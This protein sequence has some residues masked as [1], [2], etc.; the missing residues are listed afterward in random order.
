M[1]DPQGSTGPAQ[2]PDA[3]K[4][5]EVKL[6]GTAILCG[7]PARYKYVSDTRKAP[8]NQEIFEDPDRDESFTIELFELKEH[9]T[10]AG[11]AS[12]FLQD[13]AAKQGTENSLAVEEESRV[14]AVAIPNLDPSTLANAVTSTMA[15]AKGSQGSDAAKLMRVQLANIRLH[16]VE[17]DIVIAVYKPHVIDSEQ[18]ESVATV[19][20]GPELPANDVPA[21]DV[22]KQVLSTF[23]IL[24]WSL[25]GYMDDDE[26]VV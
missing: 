16:R 25:F 2:V 5:V 9:V 4:S 17:T 6:F 26:L 11:S 20:A 18:S 1:D 3:E 15:I 24:D 21:N 13:L 22:F 7:L 8:A 23:K 10:N 14:P 19:D 12:W